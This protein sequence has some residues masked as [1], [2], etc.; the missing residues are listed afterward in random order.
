MKK[1]LLA[2]TFLPVVNLP[3]GC[4]KQQSEYLFTTEPSTSPTELATT[5]TMPPIAE[6][7][8]DASSHSVEAAY[9]RCYD[10]R[11]E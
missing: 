2:V 7:E 4:S 1:F 8:G 9:A 11:M 6:A 5:S 3:G 10:S